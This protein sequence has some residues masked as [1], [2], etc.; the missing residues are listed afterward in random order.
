MK[1]SPIA[2]HVVSA[3]I[4]IVARRVKSQLAGTKESDAAKSADVAVRIGHAGV[5]SG[6]A[7]ADIV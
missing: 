6:L 5:A 2:G 1:Q 4:V 3:L 7:Y